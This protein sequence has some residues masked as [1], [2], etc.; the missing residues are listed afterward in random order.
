MPE[1]TCLYAKH[2]ELQ[3]DTSIVLEDWV[4]GQSAWL[5]DRYYT[6]R[7]ININSLCWWQHILKLLW[8]GHKRSHRLNVSLII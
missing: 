2:I 7:N 1:A 4:A 8:M 5:Y 3:S 6:F